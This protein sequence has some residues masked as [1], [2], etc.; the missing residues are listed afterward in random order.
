LDNENTYRKSIEITSGNTP[1]GGAL[2][3][4]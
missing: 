3:I 1:I 2:S 4:V